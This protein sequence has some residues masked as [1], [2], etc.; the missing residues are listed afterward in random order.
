LID[1]HVHF[2]QSADI[3]ARPDAVDLRAVRPYADEIAWTRARLPETVMRYLRSGVTGV[4][5]MG[6][7]MWSLDLRDSAVNGAIPLRIA[8]AGPLISTAA[9]PELDSP[10]PPVIPMTTP[11]EARQIVRRI[12]ARKPDLIKILFIHN[13]GEDL[14]RQA[15]LVEVAIAE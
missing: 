8:A 6:G 3:Y 12:A 5:D 1:A 14:D 2:D 13:P 11:A 10:D 7:P 4:V 9:D 15:G